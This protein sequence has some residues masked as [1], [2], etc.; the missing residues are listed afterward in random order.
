MGA[1][2]SVAKLEPCEP[3][4]PSNVLA[5]QEECGTGTVAAE[6]IEELG[7]V[8]AGASSKVSAT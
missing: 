7:R 6:E 3:R 1:D 8:W 4:M 2:G 5:Q